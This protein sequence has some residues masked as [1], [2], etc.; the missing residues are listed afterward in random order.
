MD[1]F[2]FNYVFIHLVDGLKYWHITLILSFVP[3]IIGTVIGTFIAFEKQLNKRWASIIGGIFVMIS[4]SVPAILTMFIIY[5]G[6]H[7]F[8]SFFSKTFSLPLL[9]IGALPI[10]VIA[11]TINGIGYLT[12]TMRSAVNS[13]GNGQLE[14]AQMV[15][16]T[17]AQAIRRV[18]F[19]QIIVEALPN[20]C[21]NFTATI[22]LSSIAFVIAIVDV[23]NG[24]LIEAYKSYSYL[25][26][27][28]GAA[29]IYWIL[30]FFVEQVFIHSEHYAKRKVGIK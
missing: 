4:K 3:C 12:E 7:D 20:L 11:L 9:D 28:L 8:L 14:A 16:M 6:I 15:G 21:N 24:T 23:L 5:Y 25:E 17:N 18:L 29:V 13:V 27:Y 2:N 10:A 26:A 30:V 1:T 22:K 19:P